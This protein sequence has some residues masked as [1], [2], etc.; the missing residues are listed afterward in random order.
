VTD[1]APATAS[2]PRRGLKARLLGWLSEGLTPTQV[3]WGLALGTVIGCIPTL[4][5]S[6]LICAGV[7]HGLR[8]NQPLIQTVNYAM[9]PLQLLLLLPFWR[10]GEWLFGM[11]PV[12]L[13]DVGALLARVEANPWQATLDY[14]WVAAAGLVV[15]ALLAPLMA[16][17]IVAVSRPALTHL[18]GRK[19][20]Q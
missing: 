15:W 13:L 3:A 4:G 14:L 20:A 12:P 5:V 17:L 16:A 2:A 10:A 11:D 7:A 9:Y 18:A 6:T 8:I 19:A 1:T